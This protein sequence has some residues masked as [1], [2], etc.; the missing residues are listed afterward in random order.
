MSPSVRSNS[1]AE[2]FASTSKLYLC[3]DDP[4]QV[5]IGLEEEPFFPS[6]IL[7]KIIIILLE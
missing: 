5:E 2:E 3:A 1:G 7:I 4:E 6:M